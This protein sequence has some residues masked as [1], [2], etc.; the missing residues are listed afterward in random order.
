MKYILI[1]L[2]ILY[3]ILLSDENKTEKIT[4]GFGP[5]IQSQP[6]KNVDDLI[7][8]SPVFFYDNN[9]IYVR[10]TRFGLYFLGNSSEE[11]SWG[12]SLTAQPRTN[13]YSPDDSFEMNGLSEK[14]NSWEGGLAFSASLNDSYIEIMYLHDLLNKY[15]SY[16]A[17]VELGYSLEYGKI[18]FY[19]SIVYTYQN[20]D[21]LNYYYGVSS[22]ET[23]TSNYSMYT[24]NSDFK[25]AAQ[26]YINYKINKDLS[27]LFNVRIDFLSIEA[28]NSPLTEK[29]YYYS[30]LASLI[31]T[32][33]Y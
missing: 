25:F 16:I 3:S 17:K 15:N 23:L 28:R 24:P 18:S 26:S 12:F 32:F 21:F 14:E 10:W 9:L 8:A 5:Y 1:L 19:P 29:N 7:L 11:F 30:G 4:V 20:S 22:N 27:A 13:R 6:Y 31:Y 33:E 2:S